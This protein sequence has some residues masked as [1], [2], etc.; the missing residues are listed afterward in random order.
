MSD[1]PVPGFHTPALLPIVEA[2]ER[3][4]NRLF[5]GLSGF[6]ARHKGTRLPHSAPGFDPSSAYAWTAL[7]PITGYT[8]P[9]PSMAL[10]RERSYEAKWSAH[11]NLAIATMV[12]AAAQGMEEIRS[13]IHAHVPV[14]ARH[15]KGFL[16]L[17]VPMD[18]AGVLKKPYWRIMDHNLRDSLDGPLESCTMLAVFS[19]L[20]AL[21]PPAWL[22]TIGNKAYWA[23]REETA[24]AQHVYLSS[25]GADLATR[26]GP[27]HY[28]E[29]K[30]IMSWQ[31]SAA[32]G[33]GLL[34]T[35]RTEAKAARKA[36]KKKGVPPPPP[37]VGGAGA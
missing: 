24:M 20:A 30:R 10:T 2:M 21:P 12:R 9:N 18:H 1:I 14:L 19:F 32:L 25:P 17:S 31:D 3:V 16:M 5:E 4:Q 23:D 15:E 28:P 26:K 11:E 36:A 37:A 6:S 22:Y 27:A 35:W 8:D 7:I 13:L 33:M 29:I 34:Q